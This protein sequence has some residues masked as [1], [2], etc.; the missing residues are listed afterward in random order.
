MHN[1]T[2]IQYKIQE[3]DKNWIRV[4]CQIEKQTV[5]DSFRH[6]GC[7]AVETSKHLAGSK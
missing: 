5:G 6:I 1:K 7:L 4:M 3:L 2:Y